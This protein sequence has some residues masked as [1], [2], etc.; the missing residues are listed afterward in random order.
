MAVVL[1]F[2]V[3]DTETSHFL[4]IISILH[5]I[6][7]LEDI[8]YFGLL[9]KMAFLFVSFFFLFNHDSS[10]YDSSYHEHV[11]SSYATLA[12][13]I[14]FCFLFFSFYMKILSKLLCVIGLC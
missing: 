11:L 6:N 12:L 5:I 9:E 7:L 1:F 10:Y 14:F 13:V 2:I 3:H 4:I 8:K